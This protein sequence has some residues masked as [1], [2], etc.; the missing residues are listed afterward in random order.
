MSGPRAPRDL[1]AAS[2]SETTPFLLEL[3]RAQASRRT[4]RDLLAQ[5]ER[6]GFVQPSALDLRLANRLDALA[7]DVAHEYE[8]LLLS[9]VAPLGAC[10]VLAPTSQDRTISA[11]RGTEVVSDPTNV[12]A[13]ECARRLAKDP[14]ADVRLCTVHQTVRAQPHP[15]Q[16]GFSPHFRMFAMVEAGAARADDGFE[17]DAFERSVRTIDRVFDASSALGCAMPGRRAIVRATPER[18]VMATR[19]IERLQ[20]ALPHVEIVREPLEHAYYDGL[21]VLFGARTATGAQPPLADAGRFDWMTK[22]TSNRKM[23]FVATG[24]G[25]QLLPMLFRA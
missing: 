5:R 16:P 21:R 11:S 3:A 22:L 9:P 2:S 1:L 25:I 19:V 4:P 15:K 12:L 14:R 20:R 18:E 8:A 17:V 23:R 6:D 24:L 13:L 7:L 10:S